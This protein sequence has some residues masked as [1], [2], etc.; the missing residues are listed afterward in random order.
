MSLIAQKISG[1]YRRVLIFLILILI[2][3]IGVGLFVYN[4]VGGAEGMRYW[5]AVRALN[6]TEKLLI[7]NRPDGVPQETVTEQFQNVRD[8][9]HN[10]Q[11]DLKLLYDLLNSYQTKFHNAG[12]STEK[13]EPSTPE[14]EEF[15]TNLRTT[16][17]SDE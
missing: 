10:R 12:L 7:T 17:I 6:G 8:A 2:V 15:L 14:V 13:I 1:C 5:V 9:I 11:I 3:S 4:R 16:I